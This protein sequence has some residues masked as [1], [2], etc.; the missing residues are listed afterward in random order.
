MAA[1]KAML[2]EVHLDLLNHLNDNDNNSYTFGRMEGHSVVIAGLPA[3]VYGM[4]SAATV[5]GQMLSRF[6][7]IRFGL[8]VGVGGGVPGGEDDIRLGDM[9][10]N[11]Y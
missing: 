7:R 11:P 4:T 3:G 1:A 9:I 8:M 10:K 2:D 6:R 5:A